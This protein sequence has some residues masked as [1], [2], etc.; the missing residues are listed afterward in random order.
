[1]EILHYSYKEKLPDVSE[2]KKSLLESFKKITNTAEEKKDIIKI[3]ALYLAV[4][5]GSSKT[6]DIILSNMAN[7]EINDS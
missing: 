5:N 3:S 7:I 2:K 1:L 6:V 4:K